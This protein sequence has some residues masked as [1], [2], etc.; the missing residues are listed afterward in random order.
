MTDEEKQ[1]MN[2]LFL[3]LKAVKYNH[4]KGTGRIKAKVNPETEIERYQYRITKLSL[5]HRFGMYRPSKS[6]K[7][8]DSEIELDGLNI[9]P[10]MDSA[11]D[12]SHKFRS[13]F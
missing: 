11:D 5:P 2:N 1:D 3:L 12:P 8:F 9:V 13:I 4:N 6:M 10:K 7:R